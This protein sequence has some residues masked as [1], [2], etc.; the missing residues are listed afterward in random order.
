MEGAEMSK[1]KQI[2]AS[3][4]VF[5]FITMVL[6]TTVGAVGAPRPISPANSI[7]FSHYP[8]TTTLAWSSVPN[9]ESYTLEVD[10]YHCCQQNSWCSDIGKFWKL[11]PGLTATSYTFDFVGKQPGRWRVWSVDPYGYRSPKS[12]WQYFTYTR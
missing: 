10:C 2:L 5:A 3:L 9:A 4:L 8:R 11:V 7:S 6:V 1:L 12:A